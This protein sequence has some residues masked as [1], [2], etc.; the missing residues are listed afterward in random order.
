M[1]NPSYSLPVPEKKYNES[2]S[3]SIYDPPDKNTPPP[4]SDTELLE[5]NQHKM[6]KTVNHTNNF[7]QANITTTQAKT[8]KTQQKQHI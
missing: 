8:K 2:P 1:I 7:N 6:R 3:G 4:V 5:W